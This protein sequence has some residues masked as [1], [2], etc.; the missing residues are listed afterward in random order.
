[1]SAYQ[2][3]TSH[4]C[5][6]LVASP[7]S[8]FFSLPSWA[9]LVRSLKMCGVR[10]GVKS[11]L[12]NQPLSKALGRDVSVG[13]ALSCSSSVGPLPQGEDALQPRCG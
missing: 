10:E 2:R 1:M 5:V 3:F 11:L 9:L 13:P 8:S 4:V 6:E 12:P 7:L